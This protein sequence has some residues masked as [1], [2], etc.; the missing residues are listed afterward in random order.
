M[1]GRSISHYRILGELGSG[2]MGVVYLAEDERL[3]RQVAIK[4]LPTDAIGD[5]RALERFRV[6]A[7]AAS[8]LSHPGI[9]AIHDIGDDNGKPFI[10]MEL[11]KGETLRERIDRGPLKLTEL[12]DIGIQLADALEA[13]HSQGIIH[14]DIKPANIFITE[15]NRPKILDFGLAKLAPAK[16]RG[17]GGANTTRAPE[18]RAAPENQITIPGTALGTVC[19]MSPEQ[20]RGEEIDSRSDIFSLGVV[21][22][23]MATGH[24]A[25]GGSTTAVAF[26]AI[27]NRSPAPV[28]HLNPS[29][30]ERLESVILTAIEKDPA[31]RY[32]H[33]ADLQ[34]ELRRVRR[35]LD[36]ASVHGGSRPSMS[37]PQASSARSARSGVSR[38]PAPPE[39]GRPGWF[40]PAA[41]ATF[42]VLAVVA[43]AIPWFRSSSES[44]SN[45]AATAPTQTAAAPP[46]A[47]PP[48]T[49]AQP[50]A[51]SPAVSETPTPIPATSPAAGNQPAPSPVLS[52]PSAVESARSSAADARARE[53]AAAAARQRTPAV[54][55]PA[56][57]RPSAPEP[58]AQQATPPPAPTAPAPP[59]A[60]PPAAAAQ[61]PAPAAPAPTPA[62]E[63]PP[64]V[65]IAPPPAPAP[66]P[67]KPTTPAPETVKLPS[68][69]ETD[70]AAIRAVIATYG[71]AIETKNIDLFR[72]VRPG[73][74]ASDEQRLRESFRQV[75]SQQVSIRI[76]DLKISGRTATARLARTD[77]IVSAGRRQTQSSQQTLQLTKVASGWVIS[78]IGR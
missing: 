34:A 46:P 10:V 31:L 14:R 3:G 59:P 4:F 8:Q 42:A 11:L 24:Q 70:E 33:A 18:R 61:A 19:Y 30:P 27:L 57:S 77:T 25:F 52:S 51:T 71:R 16:D 21:L 49:T 78:E 22:Y 44:P 74:S 73:L 56:P 29:M 20:A 36:S 7:R 72:S 55:P 62:A 40:W 45:N 68:G 76:S 23:E 41:A 32:Q 1:I 2:G 37:A 58:A 50:A 75:D 9:C 28:A 6:E 5:A 38:V 64:P 67:A 60:P 66:A 17:V 39:T 48:S 12:L 15:K 26:D 43:V 13:A 35:D 69:S 54:I 53:A 47:A 65:A 63:T